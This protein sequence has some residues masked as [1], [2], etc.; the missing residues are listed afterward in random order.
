MSHGPPAPIRLP[1]RT[2][3]VACLEDDGPWSSRAQTPIDGPCEECAREAREAERHQVVARAAFLA[4]QPRRERRAANL[5][6]VL[7]RLNIPVAIVRSVIWADDDVYA[8]DVRGRGLV[9]A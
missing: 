3:R 2:H 7:D 5:A 6:A 1:C 9:R 8:V 4:A